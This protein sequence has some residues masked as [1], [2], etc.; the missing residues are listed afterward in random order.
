MIDIQ[1]LLIASKQKRIPEY[2]R[3]PYG[4]RIRPMQIILS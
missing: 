2:L 4:N 3:L 1:I